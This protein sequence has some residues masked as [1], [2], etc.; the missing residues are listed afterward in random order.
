MTP[1]DDRTRTAPQP[2][3]VRHTVTSTP[4]P[5]TEAG[6]EGTQVQRDAPTHLFTPDALPAVPGY[7]VSRE[8]ARG[9]MGVVY[10]AHDPTFDREV[11]VKVMHPGQDAERFVIESKVTAQLPHPGIPP[12]YA[13]GVLTDGRPFLAMKLIEGRTLADE[14]KGGDLPRLLGIFEQI[15]RA[16]GFAHARGIIH[17]DLKPANVMVGAFGEV[18]VMDWGLAKSVG[19]NEAGAADTERD[20]VVTQAEAAATV[21]GCVKG[22]PAYMAPEQARGEPVDARADVFALGGILAVTLTGKPPF[23]G[24]SVIDTVLKAAQA[25]LGECFAQLD[26]CGADAELVAVARRCLAAKAADRYA[27]GQQVAEAVA[28]YRAGVE[29]RLQQAERDRAVSAAE[30]REQHKR[31]RVQLALAGVVVLVAVV[32]G[33]VANRVQQQ[34]DDDLRVAEKQRADDQLAAEKRRADDRIAAEK[35]LADDRIAAEEKRLTDLRVADKKRAADLRAADEEA[36]QKQRQTRAGALADALVTADTAGVSRLIE[37]LKEYRGLTGTRLRELAGQPIGTKPGLHARL[38]LLADEPGRAAEVAAYLP[39]CRPEELLTVVHLLKPHAATVAPTLWAVLADAQAEAGKRVRAAGALAELTPDDARWGTVAPAVADAVVRANPVEFVVWAQA[40]EPVRGPLLPA[41]VKRYPES[42]GRIE[43]GKLGVSELASEAAGFDLTAALLARYITDQPTELA[44]LALTADPRHYTLLARALNA[45]KAAVVP[46]LKAEL[47]KSVSADWKDAPLKPEWAAVDAATVRTVEGADG[48]VHE[49]FALVQS[50]PLA[51][52]EALADG[53][54][55]SGYR[56]VRVRPYV[57][58]AG[59]RVAAVWR[60]DGVAWKLLAGGTAKDVGAKDDELRAAGFQPADVAAWVDAD[61]KPRPVEP[62]VALVGGAGG[63]AAASAPA[64]RFAAVW[65]AAPGGKPVNRMYLGGEGTAGHRDGYLPYKMAKLGPRTVQAV[66]LPG[67]GT[68]YSGVW[69]S[70]PE[71]SNVAWIM[72]PEA[73]LAG[74]ADQVAVDITFSLDNSGTR[75][76][77]AV[78]RGGLTME[79]EQPTRLSVAEQLAKARVLATAGWRPVAVGVSASETAGSIWHR[80]VVPDAAIEAQAKR[81]GHAAAVLLT[82]G[83]AESTWPLFAFPKDGDPSARSYLL[84][85]LAAIGADPAALVRRFGVEADVSARRA[86]LIALGDFPAE[87]VPVGEREPFV[88]RLLA[89]Y[90][91]DPDSGLHSAID[92][93][94]RQKWGKAKEL[95]AIDAELAR[96][97]RVRVAARTLADAAV[98]V[99]IAAG[100][101]GP[102]LPAPRVAVGT[103]W[104][105]NGE[106]QTFAVVRGPVEFTIGSP[107]SEPGQLSQETAH[108]KRIGRSFAIGTKEVTV[109]QFLRFRPGHNW[110]KRVQSGPGHAGGVGD[111]VRLCGVLQ[112]AE[113][114][115]GSRVTSGVTNR[116]RTACTRKGWR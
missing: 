66:G 45:N 41:L 94:L 35:R 29:A 115:R 98:P 4:P 43:T 37:D 108:R 30:V 77:A 99:G 2:D 103:D 92:W 116:T 32:S 75:K 28:A 70:A 51:G 57:S 79:V 73:Y 69:G 44:E 15:C 110:T 96:E 95:A 14:L 13:L 49:R 72:T 90:R 64:L 54:G 23:L 81:Q 34:R 25:E 93:L 38:A 63:F 7:S 67:V 11:A 19:G 27:D 111:L 5:P 47:A 10:A 59:V 100:V 39:T 106:G 58:D 89:L 84:E 91:D 74:R 18:Q 88:S 21:A 56:P 109:A 50:L 33:V 8:I 78:W 102:L 9:G 60:R 101:V 107:P 52:F 61:A 17:R 3:A 31:R 40:L 83:E 76:Y 36:K 97:S 112:L 55:R 104:Y 85:R 62:F 114:E 80:P 87:L 1:P 6:S 42:R 16:V 105:V 53:L 46:V 12:V 71:G 82:L 20:V 113:R 26:A 48:L 65:A 22:T 24:E 86:L 68:W